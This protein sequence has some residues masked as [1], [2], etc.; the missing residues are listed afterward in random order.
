MDK[1]RDADTVEHAVPRESEDEL[2]DEEL[3]DVAG[4]TVSL[5]YGKMVVTY[6]PQ[7]QD[8]SP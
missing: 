6:I 1:D 3:S 7:K 8:G 5:S 4:G 2:S